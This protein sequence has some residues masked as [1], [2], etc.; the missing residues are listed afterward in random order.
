MKTSPARISLFDG[1]TLN[2]W[3]G[4]PAIWSMKDGALHGI[5]DSGGQLILTDGDDADFRLI[6]KSRL[7]SDWSRREFRWATQQPAASMPAELS[8]QICY[9]P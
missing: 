1:A 7:L 4:N 8:V 2:G 3:N 5:T 9:R 6:F